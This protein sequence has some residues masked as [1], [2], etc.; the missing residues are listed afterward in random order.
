MS[1]HGGQVSYSNCSLCEASCGIEVRHEGRRVV[2]V[3]GDDHDPFSRGFICPKVAGLKEIHEDPDRLKRPLL[4][5]GDSFEEVSWDDAIGFVAERTVAIQRDH[6]KDAVAVYT[7]NPLGHSYAGVL[8]ALLFAEVLGSNQHYSAQ[9][10]DA[11][12]RLLTVYEMYGNQALLPVPDLD[13]TEHLLVFGAN[14]L[15]SNGSIMTA[16]DVKRRL[17]AI[18]A[19][20]GRV[21]VVDPRRTETAAEA[22]EH[23]FI[24]PGTDALVLFA[25]LHTLFAEG[26]VDLG[27]LASMVGGLDA[28]RG[29]AARFAPEWRVSSPARGARSST[30][31]WGRRRSASARSP[32][33]RSSCSTS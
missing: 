28:V 8:Y 14:P 25:M 13:R 18:R 11:L 10:V 26:L 1:E 16:P 29:V 32:A 21:V 31:G 6:G 15:V 19:R 9:S 33:G 20:G 4:R 24:T 3:R 2:A 5:R 7:G 17:R 23:H 27:R 22:D 30:A 12:P